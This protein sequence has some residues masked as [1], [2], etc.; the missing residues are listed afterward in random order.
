MISFLATCI[1]AGKY[2][3][4]P[5]GKGGRVLITTI[6][7]TQTTRYMSTFVKYVKAGT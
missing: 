3:T 6:K 5:E 1:V 2:D 4:K 7:S